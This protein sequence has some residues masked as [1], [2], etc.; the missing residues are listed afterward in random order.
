MR[1]W[2]RPHVRVGGRYTLSPSEILVTKMFEV[3]RADVSPELARRSGF[4]GVVE[5][6]KVAKHGVAVCGLIST[7][8]LG[9]YWRTSPLVFLLVPR[10]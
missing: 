1:L 10:S 6:L 8:R 4:A 9:R 2:Q 3:S 5:L 7:C